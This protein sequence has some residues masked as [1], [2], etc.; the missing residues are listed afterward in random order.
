[1]R[2][3]NRNKPSS[4]YAGVRPTP[5]PSLPLPPLSLA[6]LPGLLLVSIQEQD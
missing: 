5:F 3:E 4:I 2:L 6:V 1:M